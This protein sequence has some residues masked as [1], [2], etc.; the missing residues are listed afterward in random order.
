MEVVK[1]QI[2]E[3]NATLTVNVAKADIAENVEKN[4]RDY[5]RKANVRGYRPG[6]VPKERIYKMYGNAIIV[7]ELDR[8]IANALKDYI[9]NEKLKIIGEP[10][11]VE[12]Q[13]PIDFAKADSYSFIFDIGLEPEY[14]INLSKKDKIKRY[15]IKVD[16]EMIEK[17]ISGF[18]KRFG[19]IVEIEKSDENSMLIVKLSQID[20]KGNL[21][22]NGI[23]VEDV[24]ISIS[25]VKDEEI[26]KLFI[27]LKKNDCIDFD[28]KKA[29]TNNIEI[30]SLLKIT[31][32]EVENI[33]PYF[34]LEVKT[35]KS[36][37]EAEINQDFYDKC[38]GKDI[39]K[40]EEEFRNRI[41]EDIKAS[42]HNESEYKLIVDIK[43][44]L[45]SNTEIT[46]PETFLKRWVIHKYKNNYS[47]EE[48]ETEFPSFIEN[49]KWVSIK[50]KIFTEN[51]MNISYEDIIRAAKQQI[52]TLIHGQYGKIDLSDE[53]LTEYANEMLKKEE[54]VKKI[55]D[56]EIE[57]KIRNWACDTV[58][59]VDTEVSMEEFLE[60]LK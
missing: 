17:Y 34:R 49:T 7:D 28:I 14:E 60:L 9:E 2:D 13:D 27:N 18:R 53:I 59:I 25:V 12:C 8:V 23:N 31:K 51:K 48:I 40:T 15:T 3:L 4:L 11:Q 29:F 36:Y 39:I 45:L 44:K 54:E 24:S 10:L 47:N 16:D 21:I 57:N 42:F 58:K 5:R 50:N 6:S 56:Y 43:N 46:L 52:L 38:F 35:V 30:I 19:E 20:E 32:D 26:K 37:Q 55:Y 33:I 1:N 22:E 41:S